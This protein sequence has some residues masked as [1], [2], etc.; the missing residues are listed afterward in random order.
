MVSVTSRI[1]ATISRSAMVSGVTSITPGSYSPG[2]GE[3]MVANISLKLRPSTRSSI[4]LD[5]LRLMV[6]VSR[7]VSAPPLMRIIRP[8]D[9]KQNHQK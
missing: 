6:V 7:A 4:G 3:G 1:F 9:V 5:W 2:G 8:L